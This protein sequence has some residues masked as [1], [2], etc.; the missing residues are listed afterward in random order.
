MDR[1]KFPLK[2]LRDIIRADIF[3]NQLTLST[4]TFVG[5]PI[6]CD[7]SDS[8]SVI[9]VY[10]KKRIFYSLKYLKEELRNIN[11]Y[12]WDNLYIR[13][14]GFFFHPQFKEIVKLFGKIGK[15]ISSAGAPEPF[16]EN[17]IKFLKDN[18][19]FYLEPG[20]IDAENYMSVKNIIQKTEWLRKYKINIHLNICINNDKKKLDAEN[21][22]KKILRIL[23]RCMPTSIVIFSLTPYPKTKSFQKYK[24]K[25]SSK[26]Y[27]NFNGFEPILCDPS[28][29]D[30]YKK[31]MKTLQIEYYQSKEYAKM[32]NF[33]CGDNLNLQII[34]TQKRFGLTSKKDWLPYSCR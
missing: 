1:S 15:R 16:T 5:C 13:D 7:H 27:K 20:M 23:F 29:I 31:K 14:E 18:N 30:W 33:N 24:Y 3:S 8:C 22:F 32:R 2:S 12:P 6:L 17:I 34:D 10:G 21:Y 11:Q 25:I 9:T 28:L 26:S 4:N 19:W